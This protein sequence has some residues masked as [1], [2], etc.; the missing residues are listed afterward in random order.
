MSVWWNTL[1]GDTR[2]TIVQVCARL[3]GLLGFLIL[4]GLAGL[5]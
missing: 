5:V 1:S 3:A 2:N 4:F